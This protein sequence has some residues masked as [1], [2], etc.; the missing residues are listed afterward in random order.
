MKLR[1]FISFIIIICLLRCASQT[2]PTGGPQDKI[3]PELT[4]SN[5]ANGQKNFKGKV[6]EL[7]FNEDVKLKDPKEEI[8]ITPSPG[9]NIKYTA[10]RN[11]ATIE[12]ENPWIDSTT[13]SLTFREGIQDITEGNPAENLRLAFSTGESIDSLQ[14]NGHISTVFSEAIPEKITVALYQSDTFNIF[15]HSP[16]YF[17]KSNKKGTFSIQNL[18]AGNYYVYAF[19]DK[20]KNLKIESKTEQFGYIAKPINLPGNTDSLNISLI[21]VDARPLTVTSIR[22]T[23]K[24]TRVRFNKSIDSLKIEGVEKRNA[25]YSFDDTR[26]EVIFYQSFDSKDSIKIR[27]MTQ[28]SVYQSLDTTF[29][30]KYS[31]TKMA[32]ESFS[33]KELTYGYDL[34]T[35]Q[36]KHRLSFNKPISQ[37]NYDSLY[38]KMD[39]LTTI[40]LNKQN[41]TIDTLYHSISFVTRLEAKVDSSK[42]AK[43]KP[44]RPYLR[45]GKGTFVSIDEDSSKAISKNIV[46]LSEEDTGLITGKI[47]TKEKNYEVQLLYTDNTIAQK[48]RNPKDLNLKFVEAGDYKLLVIID[49]NGNGKWDPG[50]FQKHIEPEKVIFYKSDEGKY[51][52]PIRANWEYGPLVIKF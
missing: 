1:S 49:S 9:K 17:T 41:I 18:K 28:D 37:V 42:Q 40:N 25:I 14:I 30:L 46:F 32:K 4:E 21:R 27:M 33:L 23:D 52:F 48:L 51:S 34:S 20:N 5:P 38:I 43:V 36:L 2:T 31:E 39:S 22:Y 11:K 44:F 3:P 35:K 7:T 8:L 50:S 6:I 10:K 45:Y 29:Y 16:T 15:N 19:E 26:S 47:E 12:P 24:T 13:Y